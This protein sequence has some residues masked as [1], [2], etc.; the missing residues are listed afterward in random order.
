[1]SEIKGFP[2]SWPDNVARTPPHLRL[3]P[4]WDE[5]TINAGANFVRA[6][7]NRLNGRHWDYL[8]E[9]VVIST[10]IRTTLGGNPSSQAATPTDPGAAVYFQLRF[11]RG[12][13]EIL[14]PIVLTCDKWIRLSD[15][16]HAIGRDIEA[17]R[18]RERWGCTNYEQ[19]FRGYLAL[20]DRTGSRQWWEVLGVRS[21]ANKDE[22]KAA[23][24]KLTLTAHPDKG[25]TKS[26]WD[27]L[28][29]AYDQAMS[30]E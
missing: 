5:R 24:K 21:T 9:N 7:I 4:R 30:I 14:R 13:K 12:G 19:S 15:N 27:K 18:G 1:M 22:I 3:Y 26:E 16:L 25:G 29:N 17:Q 10:N 11:R 2:L 20:L 8:D 28:Q 6:E 23:W